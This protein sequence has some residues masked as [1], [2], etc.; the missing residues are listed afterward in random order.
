M[1]SQDLEL[2]P[3]GF[4]R[5]ICGR[6]DE[7]EQR[8][9]WLS[10]GR[11]AYAAGTVAN[12]LSRR[13]HGLLIA[14]LDPPLGR[15]LVAA[16]ADLT[17]LI[18]GEPH[19]LFANRWSGGAIQPDGN[20]H[21]ESFQLDG[22]MPVWHFSVNGV[23]L[24]QR[25]WMP[26]G[27][28][29]VYLSWNLLDAP[30][31]T[32]VCLSVDLLISARDHHSQLDTNAIAPR[33]TNQG[34]R[35]IAEHP[36]WFRILVE[37]FGGICHMEPVWVEHL[38]L[39]K[40]R[41]RGLYD[42]DNLYRAG[43]VEYRL[44]PGTPQAL[45]I[46][47]GDAGAESAQASM[48]ACLQRDADLLA[49]AEQQVPVLR[50][51]PGWVRRLVLAADAFLFARP[52]AE[53]PDGESVV[54]GYPWFGDWGRD[55]MISLP[56]LA[57]CTGR[58]DSAR[59]ILV[60]FARFVDRGMLPNTFPGAGGLAY[61]N[62]ADASLWYFEAW[63][64]YLEASAD[65]DALSAV[66]PV[67]KDMITQHCHGTRYGIGLDP[68]DGLLRAGEQRTQLTWMD[69][70][71][72]DWVVTPRIGKPVEINALWY[73][74]LCCMAEFADLLDEPADDYVRLADQARR[75]FARFLR[76]Q[77]GLF[78]VLDGPEGDD[79]SIRPNQILAVSLYHSP[80]EAEAATQ[81]VEE[82]G[83]E[84]LT[85]YGLRSLAPGH[86]E[87]RKHYKG[88]VWARDGAYHQGT[89]WAWLLGHYALAKYRVEGD[90][91]RAQALLEPIAWHLCDAGLG[92]VSE[93]FDGDPPHKARG[94]PAQAWSVA[95]TLEAWVRLEQA[96][97]HDADAGVPGPD[98]TPFV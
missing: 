37:T 33:I 60:T 2:C 24:E 25:I 22:R 21:I 85:S 89:V 6:L 86:S 58:A 83:R 44:S 62:T 72:G 26:Y 10:N 95:C 98:G 80:L 11:G 90:A 53:Q 81:V 47:V 55:T 79:P 8:E 65:L 19:P 42:N 64:A 28:D 40:E 71:V 73:N 39:P 70:K 17:L 5:E 16:K 4:G 88:D 20:R 74:A 63:R 93:I 92:T 57:L 75:G 48:R 15:Y 30:R 29:A 13:Y 68:G 14:P 34:D 9:W 96:R 51:A 32:S 46:G 12:S 7:A 36:G 66:Y 77:G 84:L 3:I 87:Y 43:R 56:G 54:A 91:A 94:A 45:C 69:A 1:T 59:R 35:I 61:F 27:R 52:L 78:D 82:C 41:E 31:N 50:H 38:H 76:S 18:D 97:L 67:L 23:R 49:Q